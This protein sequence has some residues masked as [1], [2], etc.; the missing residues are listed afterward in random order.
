MI[1]SKDFRLKYEPFYDAMRLY[2]WPYDVLELLGNIE[3]EI[4]TDF[5]E[6]EKL[7]RDFTKL[8]NEIRETLSEDED[9]EKCADALQEL[10]DSEET[11]SY[12]PLSRVAEKN[13]EN[14]KVL[15]IDEDKEEDEEGT[16]KGG[17]SNENKKSWQQY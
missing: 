1:S 6:R 7:S 9:L 15:A 16:L 3:V 10:I 5:I 12:Y 8:R 4:Y 11:D 17:V 2:L 13:Q 14:D